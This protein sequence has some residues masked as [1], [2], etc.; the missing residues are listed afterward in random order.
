[1]EGDEETGSPKVS[2]AET[3][4]SPDFQGGQPFVIGSGFYQGSR[5]FLPVVLSAA[6]LHQSFFT[7]EMTLT[8]RGPHEARL[9]YRYTAHLGGGSGVAS[10]VLTPG[11]QKIVPDAIEYLRSVGIPISESGNRVGTL[12]VE[13]FDAPEAG[14]LVR[15]TTAVPEGRAGLAYPGIPVKAG[16]QE[17]VYLC[18]L[19]QNEWDRSNVAL[20]NMGT[21]GEGSI[22]LRA[23]VFSGDPADSRPR[24]SKEVRLGPGGFHQFSGVLDGVGH[25]YVKVER[26]GGRAPFYAYGVINDQA[27]SDGSFVFPVAVSSMMESRGQ[28]LPVIMERDGFTSELMVTNFSETDKIVNLS[29]VSERVETGDHTARFPLSIEAGGQL[30]IENVIEEWRRLGVVGL[31]PAN[32]GLAGPLFATADDGDMSGIV[33]SAR[34]GTP[35]GGG[36]YSVFYNAVSSGITGSTWVDGFQQNEENRSSLAL[37]NTGEVDGSDSVFE[38]DIYDGETGMRVNTVSGITVAARRWRQIE[39]ILGNYAPGTTQGYVRITKVSGDNSFLAYGVINDGGAPG[40]RS[41]DGAYLQ[42]EPGGRVPSGIAITV[43]ISATSDLSMVGT[44]EVTDTSDGAR[45]APNLTGLTPGEHGFHVHV[46]ADCGMSGQNAGGHYDPENTGRHE[47]PYGNGHLGDL[48]R[49]TVDGQG[50]A[51]VPVFAPRVKVSDLAGRSLMIHAGG[52][53]YSDMPVALGGGGARVACGV[54]PA[55]AS[56]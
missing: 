22:T 48:P 31:G 41:G 12:S 51:S 40:E 29:L 16:F 24:S 44:V 7:S 5:L 17:A 39:G 50:R 33:I 25:G 30:R 21:S 13:V 27:N 49:L 42:A 37:V 6:G 11:A 54:V 32:S 10:D 9:R 43:Q 46:N 45:F 35:G 55:T 19:R 2:Y 52:D 15:T 38:I 56:Q 18:G 20:Q 36:Q 8:N 23:T 47:G 3:L 1:M 14:V 4:S 26:V 34:T 28:I 53:N